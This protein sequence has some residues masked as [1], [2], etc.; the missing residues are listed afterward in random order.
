VAFIVMLQLVLSWSSQPHLKRLQIHLFKELI[1]FFGIIL[2]YLYDWIA[3]RFHCEE[4][5][6]IERPKMPVLRRQGKKT[7]RL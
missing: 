6:L 3:K 1:P 4:K 5:G 7:C 2:G